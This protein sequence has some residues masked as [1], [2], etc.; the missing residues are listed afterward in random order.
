MQ[1]KNKFYLLLLSIFSVLIIAGIASQLYLSPVLKMRKEL[2]LINDYRKMISRET[3]ALGL[4]YQLPFEKAIEDFLSVHEERN[5]LAQELLNITYLPSLDEDTAKDVESLSLLS[6]LADT[7]LKALIRNSGDLKE[8]IDTLA[9]FS[10]SASFLSMYD[11][12]DIYAQG[13]EREILRILLSNTAREMNTLLS[14]YEVTLTSLDRQTAKIEKKLDELQRFR[15]IVVLIAAGL[16]I[17]LI[18][19]LAVVMLKKI[20]IRISVMANVV[21]NVKEGYLDQQLEDDGKDDLSSLIR[22][23]GL[24]L[25]S[26]KESFQSVNLSL[27][28]TMMVKDAFINLIEQLGRSIREI[29]DAVEEIRQGSQVLDQGFEES[30]ASVNNIRDQINGLDEQ[31]EQQASMVEE[32]SSSVT[33]MISSLGS[34]YKMTQHNKEITDNLSKTAVT[35][36]EQIDETTHLL[37]RMGG[38]I[39]SIQEMAEVIESIASQTNLL[40]MNAAI[41][42]AHAGEEGRGF[43]VVAEEIRKLAEA[44]SESSQEI[45]NKLID[46]IGNI[47]EAG[48]SGK[49]AQDIFNQITSEIEDVRNS[50]EQVYQSLQEVQQGGTQILDAMSVLQDTTLSVK[51]TAGSI[52]D[53]TGAV[54]NSVNRVGDISEQLKTGSKRIQADTMNLANLSKE[55]EIESEALAENTRTLQEKLSFFKTESEVIDK[56]DEYENADESDEILEEIEE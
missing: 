51:E 46:I 7:Q 23:T 14:N 41:E 32:S 45:R 54:Q 37:E 10:L 39:S 20:G 8:K 40:A 55:A 44:S 31:I 50:F 22:N 48:T 53:N 35:G 24:F 2:S 29:E 6:D 30:N 52:N 47:E 56:A 42:A 43:A 27:N 25:E 26:L 4:L 28:S 21:N 11:N 38:S 9:G 19:L 1:I 49:N 18:F 34:I 13:R 17:I 3:V 5:L 15:I 12:L 33:E 36:D 16:F